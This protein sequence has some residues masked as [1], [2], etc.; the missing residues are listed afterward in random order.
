MAVIEYGKNKGPKKCNIEIFQF[1]LS[2]HVMLILYNLVK[3][4]IS[5]KYTCIW[6]DIYWK[7]LGMKKKYIDRSK[8]NVHYTC[9]QILEDS[10]CI[11]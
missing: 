11:F 3:R 2:E 7:L 10:S 8:Q 4:N 5:H 9:K 1:Y 6:K